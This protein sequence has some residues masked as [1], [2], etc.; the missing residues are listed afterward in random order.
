MVQGARR[1]EIIRVVGGQGGGVDESRPM[2]V[3]VGSVPGR[4]AEA[5]GATG[6]I[7]EMGCAVED[8]LACGA[9]VVERPLGAERSLVRGHNLGEGDATAPADVDEGIGEG[10]VGV[11]GIEA[12]VL[13]DGVHKSP[14]SYK[15]GVEGG[16]GARD[17]EVGGGRVSAGGGRDVDGTG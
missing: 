6:V 2:E 17:S 8:D 15:A 3:G 1:L 4:A 10:A 14:T 16:R 11:E 13:A 5:A 7:G 12:A 9:G